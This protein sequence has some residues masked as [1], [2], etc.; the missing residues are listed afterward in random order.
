MLIGEPGVGKTAIVQ[1]LAQRIVKGEVPESLAKKRIMSLDLGLLIAGSIY[2]GEFEGRLKD[3][4][5]ELNQNKDIILFIDEFHTVIGTGSV[6]GSLDAA[7][8]LKPALSRG[9]LR[10]IAATTFAEFQK[11]VRK[12]AALERRFQPITVH[13]PG[14]EETTK[15]IKGLKPYFEDFH[16]VEITAE[17]VNQAVMLSKRFIT[18]RFMPDKALDIL[19]QTASYVKGKSG[20]K[21]NFLEIKKLLAKK[22]ALL[23][24]KEKAVRQENFERALKIKF[25]EEEVQKKINDLEKTVPSQKDRAK[26]KVGKEDVEKIVSQITRIPVS[27]IIEREAKRLG[28]LE[29]ILKK[30]VVG[31]DEAISAMAR[32]VRRSRAGI[33]DPRRPLGSFLMLGPSGVGKTKLAEVLAQAVFGGDK[34]LIKINMSEF[35]E[36][37]NVSRLL[38]APAGYVGYEEGGKLAETVRVKPYSVVLFD[39]VEKS[40]PDV[41]NILLQ[42]L[43]NGEIVDAQGRNVSFRNTIIIMTSNIGTQEFT[44]EASLGFDSSRKEKGKEENVL[45][46]YEKIK[47]KSLKDLKDR[48]AVELLNR[49]DEILVFKPLDKKVIQKITKLELGKL[50][51]RLTEQKI[52]A[53][54]TGELANHIAEKSFNTS[55][56]ARLIRKNIQN[57][58]ESLL[59]EKIIKGEMKEGQSVKVDF[60]EGKIKIS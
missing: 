45:D 24:D 6:T 51:K 28:G 37:H 42:I 55:Y 31:Q 20:S 38:G 29:D 2:R 46:R 59:A 48:F 44:R 43:E 4:I 33:A 21:G 40:H 36:R 25:E 22:N 50:K 34:N 53:T 30:E 9:E 58:V 47:E 19:D 49:I 39:E 3:I 18:D 32:V 23:L 16:G 27:N 41:A 17:A 35:M 11:Y 10:C 52:N 13:E 1:G 15:I 14:V 54:F 7:N 56:G 26:R 60:V 8:I 5:Y 12:D 57:M